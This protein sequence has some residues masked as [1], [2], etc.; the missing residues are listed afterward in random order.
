MY[1]E[2]HGASFDVI[3]RGGGASNAPFDYRIVARRKGYESLRLGETSGPI[4]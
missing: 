1:V 2:K 4:R 3:E